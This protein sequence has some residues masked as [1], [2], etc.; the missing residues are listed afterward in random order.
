MERE[1]AARVLY[2]AATRARDLLVVTAV[3]DQPFP[4][5]GWL[6]ALNPAIYPPARRSFQP[7]SNKPEGCPEFGPDNVATRAAGILRPPGSVT[8]GLHKSEVGE[9]R[10]V[11]WDPNLLELGK[12]DELGSRLT[13]LLAAD[14]KKVR[15]EAGIKDHAAWQ[16]ERVRVR[17][18]G[19]TPSLR[20]TTATELALKLAA[21]AAI[22]GRPAGTEPD[23]ADERTAAVA[24]AQPQ[25]GA[26]APIKTTRTRRSV[27]AEGPLLPLFDVLE[28]GAS[29]KEEA[30]TPSEHIPADVPDAISLDSEIALANL[31]EVAIETVSINFSRPHGKRFGMLV[32]AILSLADLDAD[33]T[34]VEAISELQ[35]RMLGATPKEM[36]AATE[37]VVRALEHPLL[38]RAA[39][40]QREGRC[41]RETPVAMQLEDGTLVEGKVDLAFRDDAT[42]GWTVV[43][44][45]TDF[46]IAGK[47]EEYRN[48][49]RLY[50]E[51]ISR[52]T[53]LEASG[54]LL[55]L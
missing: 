15:S 52:A 27:M 34:G 20:V 49:V 43:D 50:T 36:T 8:P 21:G 2:V 40:A 44:F 35:G 13:K 37:T 18:E 45:K 5:E 51:A 41:R 23:I 9:H 14:D 17:A 22:E 46:E 31:P 11:W 33:R 30:T 38:R 1:E 19:E 55:R 16:A 26:V 47:L 53:T 6:G 24:K 54:I 28:G 10:V 42:A 4:A 32:H 29:E 48:Q 12:K 39:A 3:G 7:E 25:V